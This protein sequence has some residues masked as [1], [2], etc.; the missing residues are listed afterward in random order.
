MSDRHLFRGK[1]TDTGEWVFGSYIHKWYDLARISSVIIQNEN[2]EENGLLD[3]PLVRYYVDPKT[4]GQCTGLKEENGTLIFE[5][6]I[7][8]Y[9]GTKKITI[10]WCTDTASFM[11][12]GGADWPVFIRHN[13]SKDFEVIGNI[14]EESANE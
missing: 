7:L 14:H 11:I 10:E 6:D 8:T 2:S 1:R 13:E 9:K 12:L 4:V 5:G 3:D